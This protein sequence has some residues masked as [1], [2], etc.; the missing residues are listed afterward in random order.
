MPPYQESAAT[1]VSK[2][3][4]AWAAGL[5]SRSLEVPRELTLRASTQRNALW[6]PGRRDP[7]D[8]RRLDGLGSANDGDGA[9]IPVH[10]HD[11]TGRD[12]AGG[13]VVELDDGG[14]AGD[15]G[16]QHRLGGQR[17]ED[18]RQRRRAHE[19]G[20]LEEPRPAR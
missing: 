7:R 17:A 6:L 4:A 20:A 11:V 14:Y 12:E 16:S 15:D 2:T 8:G 9:V 5:R 18:H 19:P 10:P 1:D 3:H 13:V